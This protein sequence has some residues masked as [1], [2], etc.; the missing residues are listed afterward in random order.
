MRTP[1]VQKEHYW[2][3]NYTSL[4]RFISFYFQIDTI[5]KL[6]PSS[7]LEIGIGNKVVYNFFK[8][9]GTKIVGG[10]HDA[11]LG[12]DIILDI[13]KLPITGGCFDIVS[14]CEV[15]EHLPFEFLPRVLLELKRVSKRYI[16]ISMP[17]ITVNIYGFVK[18]VPLIKPMYFLKRLSEAFWISHKFD[19]EHYWEMGKK[20]Y[21]RKLARSIIRDCGLEI[22]EEFTPFLNP[23]HY[24]FVLEKRKK[25]WVEKES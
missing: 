13:D 18:P 19:H 4:E 17:Y 11:C 3:E 1:Q 2:K 5:R 6:K 24:F 21:S 7:I 16:L 14:A 23:C 9:G 20:G 10:D 15:L 12:P 8:N 22:K 25:E